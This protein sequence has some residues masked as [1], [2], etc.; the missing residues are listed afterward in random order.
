MHTPIRLAALVSA[1]GTTLQNLLD[2]IADGR[3]AARIEVVIG[4]RPDAYGL[5]RAR[6]AGV[7]T[8]L[9]S[10]KVYADRTT[11]SAA[12]F[13]LCRQV[14]VDL[15]CLAGYLQLLTIPDAVRHRVI[16][17]HPS[18]LPAFGPR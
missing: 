8:A 3:L 6:R 4:S 11:F 16:N 14:G 9:V 5:E 10:R 12:N 7:R 17:I 15:V 13:D 1:G 2:R 18:L